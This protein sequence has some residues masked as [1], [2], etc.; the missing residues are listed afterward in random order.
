MRVLVT[1][2]AA[3]VA[4]VLAACEPAPEPRRGPPPAPPQASAPEALRRL[5]PGDAVL[6][7]Q[8]P[9][10]AITDE[11]WGRL[12]RTFGEDRPRSVLSGLTDLLDVRVDAQLVDRARPLMLVLRPLGMLGS[13]DPVLLLPVTDDARADASLGSAVV[14]ASEGYVALAATGYELPD[15]PAPLGADLPPGHLSLRADLPG[16]FEP[17]WPAIRGVVQLIKAQAASMPTS[18]MDMVAL[19][20]AY[21]RLLERAVAS[22]QAFEAGAW[23]LDGQLVFDAQIEVTPDS[24]LADIPPAS[25]DALE[26]MLGWL[27]D[28][29]A[30]QMV[31]GM[32]AR[33]FAELMQEFMLELVDVYPQADED[34]LLEYVASFQ[35]LAARCGHVFVADGRL[36]PEGLAFSYLYEADDPQ[37]LAE[38]VDTNMRAGLALSSGHAAV[39]E[40]T[41]VGGRPAVRFDVD[42]S[43]SVTSPGAD[44]ALQAALEDMLRRM[45]GGDAHMRWVT[46]PLADRVAVISGD[47]AAAQARIE[48]PANAPPADLLAA[49][50]NLGEVDTRC[51]MRMDV[52]RLL[53]GMGRFMTGF[54]G[55]EHNPFE[56]LDER[57]SA[58]WITS[59]GG[60]GRTW[61]LV[62]ALDANALG[63][64]RHPTGRR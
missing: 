34:A 13:V 60:K 35:V 39:S 3:L 24:G 63:A 61:R 6:V 46:T 2:T 53:V 18:T 7:L 37:R 50:D 62:S 17:L 36:A 10:L 55:M 44:P 28:G 27:D 32:D 15:A 40:S 22:T 47:D 9:S 52:A 33:A 25:C 5:V 41:S 1:V 12:S 49:L 20:D 11:A 51:V 26:D 48:R 16:L 64:L 23:Y 8:L 42:L 56:Q 14:Q 43:G 57:V 4:L 31:V 30:L 58:P 54:P 21:P 38:A 19:Y 45:Y 29:A 59:L